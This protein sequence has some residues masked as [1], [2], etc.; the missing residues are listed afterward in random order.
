MEL[1]VAH[2]T[3][4]P[5]QVSAHAEDDV[6]ERPL[7][8]SV[9][10]LAELVAHEL[11]VVEVGVGGAARRL[12]LEHPRGVRPLLVGER[13]A[14]H[15]PPELAAVGGLDPRPHPGA[16]PPAA[17]QERHGADRQQDPARVLARVQPRRHQG[18]RGAERQGEAVPQ[19]RRRAA[20]QHAQRERAARRRGRADRER[21]H[22]GL[23]ADDIHKV[24]LAQKPQPRGITR[25][26]AAAALDRSRARG[27]YAEQKA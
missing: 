4:V 25:S 9:Y 8:P 1:G 17:Q 24:Q 7:L 20:E 13:G 18:H 10:E 26:V 14:H 23:V 16:A 11:L 3:K 6:P 2:V 22:P 15:V 27:R 5:E 12:P 19:P 21:P